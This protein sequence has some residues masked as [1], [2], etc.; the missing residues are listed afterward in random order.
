MEWCLWPFK[1]V[2]VWCFSLVFIAPR[3][4]VLQIPVGDLG[5]FPR[6]KCPKKLPVVMTKDEVRRVFQ[7]LHGQPLLMARL[8]YGSDMRLAE[9]L[10]LRVKDIDFAA[11]TIHIRHGKG[12]KDRVTILLENLIA[13]LRAQLAAARLLF[14][15]DRAQN[16]P[17]VYLPHALSTK[18]P[19]A[20]K[21]WPWF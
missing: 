8:L 3:W 17:G 9:M 21:Q 5:D 10:T 15:Q 11:H 20:G 14:D 1:W 7:Q 4:H 6:A 2:I 12:G 13:P 19:N 16:L 18:Y